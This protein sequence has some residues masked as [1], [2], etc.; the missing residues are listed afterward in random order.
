MH[1]FLPDARVF[2]YCSRTD[3]TKRGGDIDLLVLTNGIADLSLKIKILGAMYKRIGEQK[4][5][6]LLEN[7]GQ[8]GDFAKLM[9]HQAQIL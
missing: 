1:D 8:L 2:L 9:L 3:D 7:E 6:L 5:D 4:I